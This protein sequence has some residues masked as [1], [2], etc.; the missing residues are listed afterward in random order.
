MYL[1]DEEEE[2]EVKTSHLLRILTTG[3]NVRQEEHPTEGNNT[4]S[5]SAL[6]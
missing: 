1:L 3:N 5:T 6:P 2:Q 4:A